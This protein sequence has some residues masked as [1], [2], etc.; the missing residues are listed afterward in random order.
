MTITLLPTL[1]VRMILQIRE[2]FANPY[3]LSPNKNERRTA[4]KL[5]YSLFLLVTLGL[6]LKDDASKQPLFTASEMREVNRRLNA[7]G[8]L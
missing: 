4:M 1:I 3:R 6:L 7:I 2:L 8:Y 5:F